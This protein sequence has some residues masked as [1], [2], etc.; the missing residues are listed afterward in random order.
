MVT[1]YASDITELKRATSRLCDELA[2]GRNNCGKPH[3]FDRRRT[4]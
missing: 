1:F 2:A 3:P 4:G